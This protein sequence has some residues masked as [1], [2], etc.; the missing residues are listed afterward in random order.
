LIL[1]SLEEQREQTVLRVEDAMSSASPASM[2]NFGES[3]ETAVG[4]MQASAE[5]V[6][7]VRMSPSGWS[8]ISREALQTLA[9]EGKGDLT[10]GSTLSSPRLPYLYPDLPLEVVRGYINEMPVL[11]VV[12]GADVQRLEG[13]ILREEVFKKY[14]SA[15]AVEID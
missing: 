5:P 9:G 6:F 14:K 11:P 13:V 7:L 2:L 4:R 12:H 15:A 3:V 10:L 8:C 1:P